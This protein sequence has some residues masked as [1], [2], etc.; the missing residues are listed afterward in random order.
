MTILLTIHNELY[1]RAGRLSPAAQ[2]VLS[3]A[4]VQRS[5]PLLRQSAERDEVRRP[6]VDLAPE[7]LAVAWAVCAGAAAGSDVAD[8]LRAYGPSDSGDPILFDDS[9]VLAFVRDLP[10]LIDE[11]GLYLAGLAN[12]LYN[13]NMSDFPDRPYSSGEL[14]EVAAQAFE[15]ELLEREPVTPELI[16]RIREHAIAVGDDLAG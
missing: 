11:P 16:E 2:R 7:G 8:R 14:L 9:S 1:E 3:V 5:L 6:V 4:A 13:H 15:I 12:L 10:D